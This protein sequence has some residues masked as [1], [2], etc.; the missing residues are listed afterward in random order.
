MVFLFV[1]DMEQGGTMAKIICRPE[2]VDAAKQVMLIFFGLQGNLLF[3][4]LTDRDNNIAYQSEVELEN[5]EP[6]TLFNA[7]YELFG[8]EFDQLDLLVRIGQF[9]FF[10][11]DGQRVAESG[12]KEILDCEPI[13]EK[14][15]NFGRMLFSFLPAPM[16][17]GKAMAA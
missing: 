5:A 12:G 8:D 3:I 6:T 11:F 13:L 17:D 10:Q 14:Y 7:L 15:P 9:T 2:Y 16:T 4:Q 1:P